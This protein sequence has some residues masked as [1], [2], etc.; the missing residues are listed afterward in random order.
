[1]AAFKMQ[2]VDPLD[3]EERLRKHTLLQCI[4][5]VDAV[6]RAET[7]TINFQFD[8]RGVIEIMPA[9]KEPTEH[10]QKGKGIVDHAM[11]KIL[12][13]ARVSVAY[14]VWYDPTMPGYILTNKTDE[15]FDLGNDYNTAV[16]KLEHIISEW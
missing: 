7:L 11:N 14:Y 3:K 9:P 10:W 1:M 8:L 2:Y 5:L 4:N 16:E 13:D 12:R 6:Q 15:A